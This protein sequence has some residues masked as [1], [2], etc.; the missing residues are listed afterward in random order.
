MNLLKRKSWDLVILDENENFKEIKIILIKGIK[1]VK[2]LF[3]TFFDVCY[4]L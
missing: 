3:Y 2:K 1:S 4:L